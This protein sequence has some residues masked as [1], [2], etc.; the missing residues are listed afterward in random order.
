MSIVWLGLLTYVMVM[1]VEKV[2]HC[3]EI[4]TDIIGVTVLAV[5]TSA[6][7]CIGSILVARKGKGDMAVSNA[8]G[9]NVFDICFCVGIPF[10]IQTISSGKP[11]RVSTEGM[12]ELLAW[13]AGFLAFHIASLLCTR[14]LL[15]RWQGVMMLLGYAG[16]AVTY[17]VTRSKEHKA[18]L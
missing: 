10:L 9:S 4:P 13:G 18:T 2:A 1:L 12:E 3:L 16:F 11:V 17:V 6:P 8:F 14:L 15:K 5:G 7:D